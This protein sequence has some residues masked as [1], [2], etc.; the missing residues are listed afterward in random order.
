MSEMRTDM[1]VLTKVAL[2]AV[3]A[4]A[5]FGLTGAGTDLGRPA[6]AATSSPVRG[7]IVLNG[8]TGEGT[9]IAGGIDVLSFADGVT[10]TATV[11]GGGGGAGKPT[12]TD[13]Q[14]GGVLDA[15][16]PELFRLVTTGRHVSTVV[17]T[18]C[19]D[20]KKCAATAYAEIDLTDAIVTKVAIGA[21][22]RVDFS[23]AYRQITWKFLRNGA[24]V[25]QSQFSQV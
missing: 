4:T 11:G 1:R 25:S 21:D 17:L 9:A 23:L 12:P 6:A 3:V 2:A 8:V 5:A 16:Y 15:A 13:L 18:A 14:V 19:T 7:S 24:V 22:Q 10:S 20:P